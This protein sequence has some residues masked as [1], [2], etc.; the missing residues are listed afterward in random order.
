M[1]HGFV[2]WITSRWL[3]RWYHVVDCVFILGYSHCRN[4]C[5]NGR[6]V[7]FLA[8]F[9]FALVRKKHKQ[10]CSYVCVCVMMMIFLLGLSSRANSIPVKVML[11]H[12]LHSRLFWKLAL[13]HQ[14]NK[15]KFMSTI[16]LLFFSMNLNIFREFIN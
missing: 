1:D 14:R 16:E 9:T 4:S 5:F 7:G 2:D 10:I 6:L 3:V 13:L 8:Y 12:H 11:L 15:F